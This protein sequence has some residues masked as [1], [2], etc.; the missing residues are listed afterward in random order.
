M[1]QLAQE[2]ETYNIHTKADGITFPADAFGSFKH[3]DF[4]LVLIGQDVKVHALTQPACVLYNS[5]G[6]VLFETQHSLI[7]YLIQFSS[8]LLVVTG[9]QHHD[10]P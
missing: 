6:T 9:W 1:N 8:F 7:L 2:I 4:L 5:D 10:I 3:F